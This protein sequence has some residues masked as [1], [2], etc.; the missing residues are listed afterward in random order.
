MKRGVFIGHRLWY[1]AYPGL[2]LAAVSA[3]PALVDM[4]NM[5]DGGQL[6]TASDGGLLALARQ[7]TLGTY[8]G[9]FSQ[10]LSEALSAL[11]LP[12]VSPLSY[13]AGMLSELRTQPYG[14][15]ALFGNY[16]PEALLWAEAVSDK[17]EVVV[18]AA[19]S[20][21]SQAALFLSVQGLLIGEEVFAVKGLV[22]P[23]TVDDAAWM[24]EDI[25]RMLLILLI[26]IGAVLKMAG[27]L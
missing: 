25:L 7:I 8:Q 1:R 24:A 14:S 9:G 15:L 13:T 4:E 22:K 10:P 2:G 12:G 19:G 27:V 11:S 20:L 16:G 17:N 21:S 6:V 3:L 5:A 18:A 26:V 23:E